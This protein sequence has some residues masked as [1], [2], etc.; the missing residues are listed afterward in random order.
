MKRKIIILTITLIVILGAFITYKTGRTV[1][2][3]G[4]RGGTFWE[5]SEALIPAMPSPEEER[6]DILLVGIRGFNGK[7]TEGESGEY[8]ADTIILISFNKA[9]NQASLVSIPRDLYVDIPEHGK[10]KINSAYA[11]GEARSYGGGGLK[12]MKALLSRISG[13]YIDHAVSVDFEGFQKIIDHLGGI[14]VYRNTPFIED[15]QWIHDGQEGKDYWRLD[16]EKGWIF[17]VPE[18]E[19]IMNSEDV[20]YYVRSRYSS[21]DFDRMRRQHEVI[22][23]IKSKSL[24]L[25]IIANPVRIFNILKIVENNIRIDTSISKIKE[26]ISIVQQTNIQDFRRGVLDNSKDGLLVDDKVDGRFVL[27]PKVEDYSE[28]QKFFKD[29]IR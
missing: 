10:E 22:S 28:I 18:G 26:L 29:I 20:L 17:Y 24:N 9:N 12:L 19:N 16:E 6:I 13:V 3:A 14:V 7:D 15:K 8:L 21:S 1:I 11:I 4:E 25:G 5:E 23:A 2:I 27:L